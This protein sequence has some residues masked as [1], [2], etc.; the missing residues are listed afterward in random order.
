MAA[1]MCMPFSSLSLRS[2][3]LCT[4]YASTFDFELI[5]SN[6]LSMQKCRAIVDGSS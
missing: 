3:M 2:G 4:A 6:V 5:F 1:C